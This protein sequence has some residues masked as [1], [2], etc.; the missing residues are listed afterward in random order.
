M[1]KIRT[2]SGYAEKPMPKGSTGM[3]NRGGKMAPQCGTRLTKASRR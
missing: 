1:A 3:S 2:T